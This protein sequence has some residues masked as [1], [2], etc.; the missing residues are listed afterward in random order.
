MFLWLALLWYS[1]CCCLEPHLWYLRGTPVLLLCLQ[2]RLWV[3]RRYFWYIISWYYN[4]KTSFQTNVSTQAQVPWTPKAG[5]V[6]HYLSD[7]TFT[8]TQSLT[9]FTGHILHTRWLSNP[10]LLQVWSM[11]QNQTMDCLLLVCYK[12]STKVKSKHQ[13]TFIAIWHCHLISGL[14]SL[15]RA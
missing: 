15:D 4:F 5:D 1:L 8:T 7:A 9:Q 6:S 12:V 13:E 11:E 14:I 2:Q 3:E 10:A